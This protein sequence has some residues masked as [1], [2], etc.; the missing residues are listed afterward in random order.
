MT[1]RQPARQSGGTESVHETVGGFPTVHVGGMDI[2]QLA[3]G[4]ALAGAATATSAVAA[5]SASMSARVRMRELA[6]GLWMG[7]VTARPMARRAVLAAAPV[8]APSR[9]RSGLLRGR[10]SPR[11]L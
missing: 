7:I 4:S 5:T 10:G 3:V 6:R 2:V 8:T 1:D 11:R 9:R